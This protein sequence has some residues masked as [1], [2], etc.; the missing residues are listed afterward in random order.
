VRGS[1]ERR[2][3][4]IPVTGALSSAPARSSQ[5]WSMAAMLSP[6]HRSAPTE[7]VGKSAAPRRIRV[8]TAAARIL[9]NDTRDGLEV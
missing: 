7:A 6:E 1:N 2:G 8:V 5:Y 4:L 9:L 3:F